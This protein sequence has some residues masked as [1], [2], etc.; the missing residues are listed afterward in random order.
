MCNESEEGDLLIQYTFS[1]KYDQKLQETL[2]PYNR[3]DATMGFLTLANTILTSCNM[4]KV[5]AQY[6]LDQLL[7]SCITDEEIIL[8]GDLLDKTFF[9]TD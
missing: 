7:L 4:R 5:N 9:W 8:L 6:R 3:E 1:V 2:A